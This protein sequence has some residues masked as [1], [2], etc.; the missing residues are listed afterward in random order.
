MGRCPSG[1]FMVK[2]H[3]MGAGF[4][5]AAHLGARKQRDK[6]KARAPI[7]PSRTYSQ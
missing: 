5:K 3:I 6:E 7:S 1:F 4:G 2:D